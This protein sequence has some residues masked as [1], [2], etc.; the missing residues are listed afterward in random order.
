MPFQEIEPFRR[1]SQQEALLR[2]LIAELRTPQTVGQPYVVVKR[3]GKD[4]V[5]HAYVYWDR[6]EGC[7]APVRADIVY[8]GFEEVR[9]SE[10]T[11]S[12]ALVVTAT[13]PEAADLGLLPFQVRYRGWY[14]PETEIGK[15]CNEAMVTLGASV[16]RNPAHP[17][18]RFES[19]EDARKAVD[20]LRRLVPE[21]EWGVT[22]TVLSPREHAF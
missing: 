16:L 11:E 4:K 18:L 6:W 3:V 14:H 22:V 15:R 19:E 5:R 12:I 10:Y 21:A 9:G 13:I 1:T 2:D 7:P 20:E 17:E 8:D